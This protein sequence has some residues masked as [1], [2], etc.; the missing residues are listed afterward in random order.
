[1][2][3]LTLILGRQLHIVSVNV[4]EDMVIAF[5]GLERAAFERH[6]DRVGEIVAQLIVP[7]AIVQDAKLRPVP[8]ASIGNPDGILPHNLIVEV[9]FPPSL[10]RQFDGQEDEQVFETTS[11]DYVTEGGQ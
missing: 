7:D 1:M 5:H 9:Q 3:G 4:P 8:G 2:L 11:L 6:V 10:A